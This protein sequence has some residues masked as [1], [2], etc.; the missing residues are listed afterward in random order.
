MSHKIKFCVQPLNII[1]LLVKFK[2]L[3]LVNLVGKTQPAQPCQPFL[4]QSG[5][6]AQRPKSRVPILMAQ[7]SAE[8]EGMLSRKC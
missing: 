1:C 7:V 2:L 6:N 8:S 3:N 4:M 5:P